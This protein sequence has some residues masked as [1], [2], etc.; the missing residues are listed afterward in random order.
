MRNLR[1]RQV[2]LRALAK[3]PTDGEVMETFLAKAWL[4]IKH[5]RLPQVT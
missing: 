3:V 2:I 1:I 5:S 4:C